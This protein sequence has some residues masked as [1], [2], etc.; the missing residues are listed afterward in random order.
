MTDRVKLMVLALMFGASNARAADTLP[1]TPILRIDTGRHSAFIH[2][3]ALDESAGRLYSASED[4]T[5]RVWRVSDGRLLDTFRVPIGTRSDGQLYALALSPD[6]RTLAVGGWT[7]WD[8]EGSACIYLLDAETGALTARIR[9]L[10]EV[11]A[12]LRFSPDGTRLAAGMMGQGGLQVYRLSDRKLVARDAAYRDKLLELDFTLDGRLVAA[13]LDGFLRLYDRQ[14]TLIGRIDAGLA[15]HQPFGLRC[16]PDG[17]FIAVGFNDVAHVSVLDA[18]D[19][20]PIRNLNVAGP[21][22][23]NLTRVGW[24]PDSSA[25]YATGEPLQGETATVFRWRVAGS[26]LADRAFVTEGRIGDLAVTRDQSVAFASDEPSLG[27]LDAAGKIRYRLLSGIPNYG[28]DVR[29]RVA[30]D[31]SEVEVAGGPVS[32]ELRRFSV[33]RGTLA[34]LSVP[35]PDLMPPT[36]STRE[37]HVTRWGKPDGPHINGNR[38]VL[39]PYE[40]PHAFTIAANAGTL[41]IGT[42][43]ALRAVNAHGDAKWTVRTST[44]VR[45]VNS[46]QDG[47]YAV[48]V[49]ADG[50]LNW[51]ALADGTLLLSLFVHVDGES[52]V[53]WTPSGYYASSVYGDSLV[54]WQIN[55]GADRSPDFFR[56]VQFERE[57]YRPDLIAARMAGAQASAAEDAR[58]LLAVAPPRVAMNVVAGA[59]GA[60]IHSQH[61]R[62]TGESTGLPMRD[63]VVYVN[64][65]PVTRTHERTLQAAEAARFAREIDV[66]LD[67]AENEVRVEVFNGRSLGVTEKLVAGTPPSQATDR[68]DL[69]VLAVGANAFPA[70]DRNLYLSYAARDAQDIGRAL[71]AGKREFN[72]VH[73]QTLSDGGTLPTRAAVLAALEQLELAGGR[74]TVIVFLAS[75]G[76]SD[77]A[78]NYFFV[79]RDANKADIDLIVNNQSVPAESSLIGWRT[80]FDALRKT[81]G[82]RLLI[83][84]TCA[85]R[86][87]TG[88]VQEFSLIKRS[89]SSHIAFIMASKADEESQ[90]YPPAHHGLFTYALL[91]GLGGAADVDRDGRITVAEWFRFAAVSVERLR[92]RRIGPQTPQFMAP[93]ALQTVQI[94][95]Y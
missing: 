1:A 18:R 42:E 77:A 48:A 51:Y 8:T 23:R 58:Q 3:L 34:R 15:G 67:Q 66:P 75:H 45:A 10:P 40:E 12:A 7:C 71:G 4:K 25:L 11:V 43:W 93:R 65:I 73:V 41:L 80:F 37:W 49:L 2:A 91:A 29:L 70:L 52:W 55:R 72:K 22:P 94:P 69:Y 24:S 9:G 62:I 33:L 53:A 47:R 54:G 5:V 57:L 85:A 78:G 21:A 63:V 59:P 39:E 87:I 79:P 30:R 64:D 27:M 13:S 92:D 60:G 31:G 84:D 46:S 88:R 14:L 19:L 36:T 38:I 28:A 35:S 44:A 6:H 56:A 16:S 81:A 82:K 76:V 20:E 90:E 17:R 86:S 89:A 68:G 32:G 26:A 74:D 95:R 61:L 50:T 83:V